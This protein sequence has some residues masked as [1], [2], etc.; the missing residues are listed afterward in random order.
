[1]GP[2]H[3][4]GRQNSCGVVF[5]N[6]LR[7]FRGWA[8][9]ASDGRRAPAGA[10]EAEGKAG[11][12]QTQDT[13]RLC[14]SDVAEGCA[15]LLAHFRRHSRRRGP[16]EAPQHGRSRPTAARHARRGRASGPRQPRG[17]V[18]SEACR[19]APHLCREA[20]SRLGHLGRAGCR[21]QGCAAVSST[22]AAA[23]AAARSG[24]GAGAGTGREANVATGAA[25]E[26]SST[27][28]AS[29][30]TASCGAAS[31]R[32]AAGRIA[33]RNERLGEGTDDPVGARAA[34][35]VRE[36][37]RVRARR[38]HR[39]ARCAAAGGAQRGACARGAV[40]A[41]GQRAQRGRGGETRRGECA[42][43]GRRRGARRKGAGGAGA[44]RR[45]DEGGAAASGRRGAAPKGGAGRQGV[46][47]NHAP[48]WRRAPPPPLCVARLPQP[49]STDPREPGAEL[50]G[51]WR[52]ARRGRTR[53]A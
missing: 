1:M 2:P 42:A 7:N 44:A 15:V 26:A 25:E 34:R 49:R 13:Q 47:P 14:P 45:R 6:Q 4:R 46:R 3:E 28:C 17:R 23:S 43:G 31:G 21:C 24:A 20:P 40:A 12:G 9:S 53:R 18:R 5:R 16:R 52:G 39:Q 50:R 22:A 27:C 30:C 19:A 29:G 51:A 37:R 11:R 38:A 33:G 41:G 32:A 36:L 8:T 35:K 48:A 10:R